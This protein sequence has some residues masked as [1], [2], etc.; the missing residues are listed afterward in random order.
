[1]SYKLIIVKSAQK[2]ISSLPKIYY[3]PVRNAILNLESNPRPAGCKKLKGFSNTYRIRVG[4]Y[5]VVYIIE[6]TV[7]II[8]VTRVAHRKNVY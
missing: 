3:P 7:R 5:R 1:M 2:E 8:T 6:Y 4:V